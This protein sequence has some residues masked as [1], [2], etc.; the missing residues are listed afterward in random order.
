MTIPS[1]FKRLGGLVALLG[2][3]SGLTHKPARET[4][5]L[6]A[7]T[8]LTYI[9]L[10]YVRY[11]EIAN[12]KQKDPPLTDHDRNLLERFRELFPSNGPVSL[13]L[14]EHDIGN[15]YHVRCVEPIWNYCKEWVG[16]D[17]EFVD[18]D[19]ERLH[20]VF[21]EKI[22]TFANKLSF[23]T[24]PHSRENMYTLGMKDLETRP[25]MIQLRDSLNEMGSEALEACEAL[26]RV[27]IR[28]AQDSK[29]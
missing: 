14:R 25:E 20:M 10:E 4:A 27:G 5:V 19:M 21:D 28:K 3:T 29:S 23:S 26:M 22:R 15:P 9:Y 2:A 11:Q 8:L 24:Y 1:E 16:P 12:L 7:T 13:F 17:F 18:Q 6:F